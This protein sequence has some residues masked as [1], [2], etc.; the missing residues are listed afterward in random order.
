MSTQ[1]KFVHYVL[2]NASTVLDSLTNGRVRQHGARMLLALFVPTLV[3]C[4]GSA[5]ATRPTA[6]PVI[7]ITPAPTQNVPATQTAFARLNLLTNN[8]YIVEE[9]DTLFSIAS[10]F[11]TTP[12]AIAEANRITDI[13]NIRVG[14]ALVIPGLPIPA[15]TP[16]ET[17]KRP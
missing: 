17:P 11:G 4:S 8:R 2:N 12:H 10:I 13:N 16:T 7:M 9:G 14:Q 6:K 1:H 3:A 5:V 15:A